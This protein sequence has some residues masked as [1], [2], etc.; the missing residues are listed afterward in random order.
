MGGRNGLATFA[1]AVHGLCR[2]LGVFR[3]SI[4]AAVNASSLTTER[5]AE[6]TGL[7]ATIDTACAAIDLIMVRYES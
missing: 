4:I 5:K 2:L 1:K 7:I 6:L 3:G